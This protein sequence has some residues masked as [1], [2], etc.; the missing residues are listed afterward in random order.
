MKNEFSFLSGPGGRRDMEHSENPNRHWYKI[1]DF[2][3]NTLQTRSQITNLDELYNK[4]IIIVVGDSFTFGDGVYYIDTYAHH[5][6]T[7]FFNKED[8]V[9]INVG[10]PGISNDRILQ[11]TQNWVN[12]FS[13]Q[14]ECIIV[15]MSFLSRRSYFFDNEYTRDHNNDIYT[16]EQ[17][18]VNTYNFNPS[19]T[20][21]TTRN[22]L[23]IRDKYN[24]FLELNTRI[25]DYRE[26]EKNLL[27]LKYI[28]IVYNIK[29]YWWGWL[30][31][32]FTKHDRDFLIRTF[33][34]NT[35][36]YMNIDDIND[37]IETISTD[38]HHWNG[39]GHRSVADYIIKFLNDDY[40][41]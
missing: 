3:N 8:Y 1:D 16:M 4:K 7:D 29:I 33:D 32:M 35:M 12:E 5:L 25:N 30:N 36:R 34:F 41:N 2:Y 9:V 18:D 13:S 26:F 17:S 39:R 27:L 37:Q 15:G 6:H 21:P 40:C 11:I 24:A 31:Q 23:N 14:I 38:D 10:V 22:G 19:T 28:S 20:V